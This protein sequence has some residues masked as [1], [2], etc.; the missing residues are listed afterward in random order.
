MKIINLAFMLLCIPLCLASCTGGEVDYDEVIGYWKSTTKTSSWD[1]S[2]IYVVFKK[3][4]VF[5]DENE[6]RFE[7]ADD[8][9]NLTLLLSNGDS[10]AIKDL[11]KDSLKIS[12]PNDIGMGDDRDFFKYVPIKKSEYDLIFKK[13]KDAYTS[14]KE[15][16]LF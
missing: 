11:E 8:K 15:L 6:L 7:I 10:I 3:D 13:K 2:S 16:D 1:G 5:I 14:V 9:D 4:H 12:L